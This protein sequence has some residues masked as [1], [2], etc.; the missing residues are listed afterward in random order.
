MRR[1]GVLLAVLALVGASC[2]G[3]PPGTLESA[4]AENRVLLEDTAE[5]LFPAHTY[6]IDVGDPTSAWCEKLGGVMDL[7]RESVLQKL[8]FDLQDG[9][10]PL[11]MAAQVVVYWEGLGF[12]MGGIDFGDGGVAGSGRTDEG[13]AVGYVAHSGDFPRLLS[14]QTTTACY[15]KK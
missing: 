8:V 13:H 15:S 10:D 2:S 3:E 11:D 12:A 4:T 7:S 6:T 14:I 9:D 5:T 1:L